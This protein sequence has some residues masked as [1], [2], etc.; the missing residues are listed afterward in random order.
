MMLKSDE[1]D[2]TVGSESSEY[3]ARREAPIASVHF[4]IAVMA[5]LCIL[6]GAVLVLCSMYR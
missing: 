1:H 2:M 3:Y 5:S 6:L 4:E